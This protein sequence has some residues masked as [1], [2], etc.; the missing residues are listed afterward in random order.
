MKSILPALTAAL[1]VFLTV[2]AGAVVVESFDNA[3]KN[4]AAANFADQGRWTIN[5]PG[6][7][8]SFIQTGSAYGAAGKAVGLGGFYEV[9]TGSSVRLGTSVSQAL[10]GFTFTADFALVNRYAGDTGTFFPQDDRFGFV[11]SDSAGELLNVDFAPT[12]AEDI[13]QVFVNGLP[14]PNNGILAS[15]YNT[16]LWYTLG[17]SFSANGADLDYALT[18]AGGAITSTGTLSGKA[19]A[20]LAAIGI[21]FDVLGAV[22]G[23]NY[24]VVDNIAIPEPSAALTSFLALG[25]MSRC[26]RRWRPI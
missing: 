1:T 11:L 17:V 25:L 26:R 20:T 24:I 10:A 7:D 14:L 13:R 4:G 22:P 2:P 6:P 23:S 18:L 12:T 19:A 8:L 9:P 5:D 16:P 3:L 21:D 15:D